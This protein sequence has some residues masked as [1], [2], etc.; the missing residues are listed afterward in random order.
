MLFESEENL[1]LDEGLKITCQLI[2]VSCSLRKV[3]IYVRNTLRH[4]ITMPSKTVIGSI[5]RITDCYPVHP[6][7]HMV[8]SV[9]AESSQT[10]SCST[11]GSSQGDPQEKHFDPPVNLDHLTIEQQVVVKQ[12][13]REESGAFARHNDDVG[14]I[15]NLKMDIKLT[16]EV[17]A[18]KTYNAIPRPL[19]DEVKNHIQDLLNKDFIRKST[20]PYAAAVVCVRKRDGSLR[21]CIDYR[22]LNKKAV[23]DRHPIPGIQEILDGLG[24]NAWFSVLDQGKAYHQGSVSEDSKKFTAF[25][26]PWALYEWNRIPFGLTNA[27]SAFQRSMEESL[28]GL[29]DKICI[30]YLDDVLVYSKTFT[31]HVE[32]VGAVLKRQ[33]DWGI[34]LRPDKCDLFKNEVRYVGKVISAEGYK[35]DDKEIA[36]VQAL[37]TKPPTN[38]KELRK[39]LGFLGYYRSYVQ[40]FSR[41]AKCLYNLLSTDVTQSG[42]SKPTTRSAGAG[43]LLPHQK[44]VWNDTHQKALNYLVDVLTNPPVMAYPRFEDPFILHIDASEQG[45]GAVLYQRQEG[46]LRVIGYGSRTLTP[47]EKNYRLHSGKLEFLALKWAVTDRFRD[48]LFYAPSVKVYSDN[49]PVTYVLSTAKLNATGHRWVSELAYFNITLKYRPGKTNT[50]AEY[51]LLY[52]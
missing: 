40:D 49:N 20:S 46:R 31:Q 18:A 26:T 48:Y 52:E 34:K 12:M 22:G 30:P 37:K 13:L 43:Q 1:S 5:Q 6:E 10:P 16:D 50:D 14:F 32:D 25:T 4:D 23:P 19:Y 39:L 27:P 8:N 45:L 11:K 41:H 44:I 9:V 17:P 28:E 24:G 29:R 3:N 7:E 21:L 33:Q 38:V 36:A 35:M 51:G 47:A 42:E 2:N 15:K